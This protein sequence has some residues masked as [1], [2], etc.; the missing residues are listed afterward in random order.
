MDKLLWGKRFEDDY[1]VEELEKIYSEINHSVTIPVNVAIRAE[2]RV[3]DLTRMEEILRDARR[4]ALQDCGCRTIHHHCDA[5][6][7][8]CI[9][10]DHHAD[11]AIAQ[12]SYNTREAT[13]EEALRALKVSHEAGLVHLAYIMEGED[14]PGLICSCCPCCCHTLAGLL[15]FG[16][17][18][19][20]LKSDHVSETYTD[21]CTGCG[22]CEERCPFGAR[23]I[24][25][26]ELLYDEG[27][28]FGC[29]L[30]VSTC[31]TGAIHLV[32]KNRAQ[33]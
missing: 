27:Q 30:C 14:T 16:L 28:C 9:N 7:E 23:R 1:T 5:P 33:Q 25:D 18:P 3:L 26:V 19:H 8:T 20:I 32:E 29:G 10:L 15:R 11:E 6:L 2:Q 24:R 4:I 12:G 31:P 13:L 17:A 22:M 21:A